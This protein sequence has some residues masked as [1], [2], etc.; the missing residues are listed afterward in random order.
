MTNLD[1]DPE[2]YN[3]PRTPPGEPDPDPPAE[4]YPIRDIEGQYGPEILDEIVTYGPEEALPWSIGGEDGESDENGQ[5]S[6][7]TATEGT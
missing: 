7:S 1:P 4:G 2:G 6:R 5:E 3:S